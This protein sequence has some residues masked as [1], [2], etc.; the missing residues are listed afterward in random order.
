MADQLLLLPMPRKVTPLGGDTTPCPPQPTIRIDPAAVPHAQGYRLTVT[1][2]SA[3]IVAHDEAGAFYARQ[4]LSQLSVGGS[5]PSVEIEDWPDFANRGVMLDISRDKVP[6]MATLRGLIDLVASWKVNQLQLYVEHTFAYAGHEDVWRDASPIT[7]DEVRELKAYCSERFIEL[8]PNQNS[9][10]H[11]ERWL[12]HP[13]YRPLAETPDGFTDPWGHRR[14][15]STLCPLD[16]GS[17]QLVEGLY[18]QVAGCFDSRQLNVGCD[19][20]WD[21]GQGRSHAAAAERGAGRVYLEFLVKVL[22]AAK[23]R[24]FEP[25]FWGDIILKHP[26]LIGELPA[27]ITALTWGYEATHPFDDELVK[28]AAAGVPFYV[29]PGTSTWCSLAGRSD[30]A[31]DNLRAAAAAGKR[32]GAVGYLNTDWG[33]HGHWQPLPASYL[34]FAA[35]ASLAWNADDALPADRLIAAL[36][37]FAFRDTAGVVARAAYELGNAYL[38]TGE[39]INNGTLLF[40]LLA[41]A[42]RSIKSATPQTLAA[43]RAAIDAADASLDAAAMDRP[44]AALIVDEFRHAAAMMRFAVD[45]GIARLAGNPLPP[46]DPAMLE[47]HR[48]LWL[49]RN[50]PGGLADSEAKLQ[51]GLRL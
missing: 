46:G 39:A 2:G 22:E 6:T 43:T 47:A 23:R 16:P 50:R 5:T 26:K 35:G 17:L 21:L 19:E 3:T 33:D 7:V 24:G 38:H 12:K 27:G 9:F 11:M 32:H 14:E 20:T 15:A 42:D 48:R 25:Q 44:D 28:F 8:V 36:D 51:K 10:G 40:W 1:G 31:L 41:D 4:T 18:D 45:R 13:R 30:N 37:R 29:C 34:G 49:S